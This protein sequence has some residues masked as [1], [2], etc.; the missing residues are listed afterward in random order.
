MNIVKYYR[1]IFE[2]FIKPYKINI[3]LTYNNH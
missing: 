2:I 3:I 1:V